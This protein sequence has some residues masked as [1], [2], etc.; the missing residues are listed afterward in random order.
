MERGCLSES[1]LRAKILR[2]RRALWGEDAAP[3]PL[4]LGIEGGRVRR[5]SGRDAWLDR[6]EHLLD[7]D[8]TTHQ[9]TAD[10]DRILTAR[11]GWIQRLGSLQAEADAN[12]SKRQQQRRELRKLRSERKQRLAGVEQQ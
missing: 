6:L 10:A 7:A 3:D 5:R 4:D 1:E 12:E 9:H 2:E 11:D 8:S